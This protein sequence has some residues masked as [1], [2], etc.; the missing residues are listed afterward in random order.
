MKQSGIAVIVLVGILIQGTVA[1][2]Y[3]ANNIA[4]NPDSLHNIV[5]GK[6]F[7]ALPISGEALDRKTATLLTPDEQTI[8]AAREAQTP[9]LMDQRAGEWHVS[10]QAVLFGVTFGVLM[11]GFG[12]SYMVSGAVFGT[13]MGWLFDFDAQQN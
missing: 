11:S 3:A 9:E 1:S 4:M 10:R 2:S 5:T 12:S 7:E 6:T 8:L 13:L